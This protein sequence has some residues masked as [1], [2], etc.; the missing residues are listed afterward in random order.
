[1][2][3]QWRDCLRRLKRRRLPLS[4]KSFPTKWL[5]SPLAQTFWPYL[6]YP[7][8]CVVLPWMWSSLKGGFKDLPAKPSW[9][10]LTRQKLCRHTKSTSE[11]IIRYLD[12][13]WFITLKFITVRNR[14][15]KLGGNQCF[16]FG[17]ANCIANVK[18]SS[19]RPAASTCLS[20]SGYSRFRIYIYI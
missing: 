20:N 14:F 8:T 16:M 15:T 9:N 5:S 2:S 7:R 3:S 12:S 18:S 6:Y 11:F 10:C 13:S 19:V 1:M 4:S 17:Y